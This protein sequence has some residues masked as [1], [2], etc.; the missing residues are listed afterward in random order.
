MLHPKLTRHGLMIFPPNDR[1][2]GRSLSLYGE[3]SRGE[4]VVFRQIV[5]PGWRALDIGANVGVFTL[6]LSELVG[7]TGEVIAFEPQRAIFHMLCANIA[8]N[9]R[10]NVKC[11]HAALGNKARMV[12]MPVLDYAAEENFGGIS[13]EMGGKDA[14]PMQVLDTLDLGA[15]NFIKI[16]VEGHEREALMGG[17]KTITQCKPVLYV[18]NDRREKSPALI[19]LLLSWGYR[20][21]WHLPLLYQ[22]DNYHGVAENIFAG[23]VSCNMLCLPAQVRLDAPPELLTPIQSIQDWPVQVRPA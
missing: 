8:M 20:L 12:P 19:D 18:E 10:R 15:I 21:F 23:I 1:F 16:D 17:R 11:I 6:D 5:R 14:A 9:E 2:V 13:I 22:P 4:T 7:R 3:Y